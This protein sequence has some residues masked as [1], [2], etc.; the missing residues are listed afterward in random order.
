MA[1]TMPEAAP[2][3]T[4]QT[5]KLVDARTGAEGLAT[6]GGCGDG[7]GHGGHGH[8][9]GDGCGCGGHGRGAK[10]EGAEAPAE[11][12]GGCGCGGHGHGAPAPVEELEVHAIPRVVRHALLFHAMDV[13][14]VGENIRILAPHAPQPL[15]DRLAASEKH[16]R[17]ETL[18]EGPKDW[19]YRITRL[20]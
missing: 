20:S 19:R 4:H 16:Y 11:K 8:G 6:G 3:Q 18:E 9:N 5:F 14:P 13:L 17:V 10:A 2:S 15:F 12:R 1:E 7:H